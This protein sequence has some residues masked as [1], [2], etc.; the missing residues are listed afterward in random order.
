MSDSSASRELVYEYTVQFTGLVDFGVGLDA[1]LG[2]GPPPLEGARFDAAF[3]GTVTGSRFGGQISGTDYVHVRADGRM[4]LHIHGVVTTD[5]GARISVFA[6]GVGM[7]RAQEPVIDVR[8][9]VTLFSS[10]PRHA[11]VNGL[12]VWGEGWADMAAGTVTIRG[13]RA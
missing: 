9:N 3:A 11:W 5:N 1:I 6:D 13:Y 2:G 8:E 7:L 4:A 10:D 12:Q